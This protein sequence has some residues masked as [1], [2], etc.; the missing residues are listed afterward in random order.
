MR[1]YLDCYPCFLRQ[2]LEASRMT[3][4]APSVQKAVV[5]R[6]LA[7]LEG[8]DLTSTP[9]KMGARVHHIV[10]E[11]TGDDD[12]YRAIKEEHT[13]RALALYPQVTELVRQS[14][15]R[16]D[17]AVRLSI[18]GN[19]LDV[20]PGREIDLWPGIRRVLA[21]PFA[22]DDGPAFRESISDASRV[23]FL[24]DNAGETVFD[25]VLVETLDVPVIYAVKAA[26]VL[27]DATM[28]D[29]IDAGLGDVSV[30]VSTGSDAPGTIMSRCSSTFHEIFESADAVI[31]KGQ[32]N[33]ETLS[34]MGPQVF[35]LLQVKC[36]VI[37]R[38][39]SAAVGSIILKRG[40]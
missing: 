13:V 12:P 21:Q 30:L 33:Y 5:D 36:P 26:P 6:V 9:P 11:I 22:I 39:V 40:V 18:A 19:T 27:N 20:A 2:A 16:L 7:L 4:A 14:E 8:R 35:F 34:D 37:A 28:R 3:G 24:G 29:A 15:N 25:R 1:T 23:L 10:C 38:D 32:A 31:A 17:T